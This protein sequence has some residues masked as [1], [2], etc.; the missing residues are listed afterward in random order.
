MYSLYLSNFNIFTQIKNTRICH[1]SIHNI[2]SKPQ[3]TVKQQELSTKQK[4]R[5]RFRSQLQ[6]SRR[7]K[8]KKS[9]SLVQICHIPT[10]TTS[11]SS[12]VL[13]INAPEDGQMSSKIIVRFRVT[14]R[15]ITTT[16]TSKEEEEVVAEEG[17]S[18][19]IEKV[20]KNPNTNR[21]HT[22]R[23]LIMQGPTTSMQ[24]IKYLTILI[25]SK[26]WTGPSWR[27]FSD[28]FCPKLWVL[29]FQGT[30]HSLCKV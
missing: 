23:D 6:L 2:N 7:Q 14:N 30:L 26:I 4:N 11:T 20:T 8:V 28:K 18:K 16:K 17:I 25:T 15:A 3:M 19:I 1:L 9:L 13:T 12:Q 27:V 24:I 22:N 29:I 5:Q 10:T 21:S